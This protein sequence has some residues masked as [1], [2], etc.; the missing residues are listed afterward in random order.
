[1][2]LLRDLANAAG[3]PDNISMILV[4]TEIRKNKEKT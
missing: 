2:Q 3:A 1:M 4:E